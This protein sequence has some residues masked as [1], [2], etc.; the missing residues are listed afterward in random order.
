MQ[1][2]GGVIASDIALNGVFTVF[3]AIRIA[4]DDRK[5]YL[6]YDEGLKS[7][8]T[9]LITQNEKQVDINY[10]FM[11]KR[12]NFSKP[13]YDNINFV[14]IIL[15]SFD[16]DLM[17]LYPEAVPFFN[18]ELKPKGIYFSN[19][20]SSGR[21]SLM[22]LQ[23]LMLSIPYIHGLPPLNNGLENK[24]FMR[25][26]NLLNQN[27]YHS[28]Y[29]ANEG[30]NEE[31]ISELIK[32]FNISEFYSKEDIP[33]LHE[34]PA[35]E[36]GYDLDALEFFHN[37]INNI[38]NKFIGFFWT[39]STHLPYNQI[40][41]KE[42]KIFD[43]DNSTEQYLNR[44]R[45]S[46]YALQNFFEKSKKESWFKNTVFILVPDHRA[47]IGDRKPTRENIGEEYFSSFILLYAPYIL[48]PIQSQL[49][50]N[51]GDI[52]PT[53]ID[54]AHIETEYASFYTSLFDTK[55]KNF[56]FIYGEDNN[57]YT[58]APN[59]R[60]VININNPALD[61]ISDID[62][63]ALSLG[64]IIYSVVKSNKFITK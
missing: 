63:T 4:S 44:L 37:K 62:K 53:I 21:R 58:F 33:V 22:A 5:L 43:G 48:E 17:D 45:Y 8:Q 52:I 32:Y 20:F 25:I 29:I 12:T 24:E 11:K 26:G 9:N 54:L 10:P 61:N 47:V 15:E 23:S 18:N 64:E 50:C 49:Y 46:D 41:S 36:K 57:I 34:Y 40:L 59:H 27:N 1:S 30:K 19:A 13:K 51:I 2:W 39:T 31:R 35:F 60:G 6:M 42:L 16:K 3:E 14:I 56:T 38:N 28:I 55:R 7:I